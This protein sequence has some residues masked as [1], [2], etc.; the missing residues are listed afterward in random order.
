MLLQ[1]VTPDHKLLLI[2]FL[3]LS[4]NLLQK[5]TP[6][7]KPIPNVSPPFF[8]SREIH[9]HFPRTLYYFKKEIFDVNSVQ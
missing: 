4:S 1:L 8:I 7:Y 2:S 5:N 9:I 6:D 3:R